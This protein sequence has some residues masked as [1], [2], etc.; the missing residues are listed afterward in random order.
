MDVQEKT[1]EQGQRN[2]SYENAI[3]CNVYD[4]QVTPRENHETGRPF[5]DVKLASGTT[6]EHDGRKLDVGRY[7]FTTN[8]EP[9]VTFGEPGDP[10]AM[11]GI[12]FPQDWDITLTKVENIAKEGHSPVFEVTDRIEGVR[13]KELADGIAERNAAWRSAHRKAH[14][15]QMPGRDEK[16]QATG[17]SAERPADSKAAKREYEP[18]L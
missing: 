2:H 4:W 3:W 11:R 5:W 1:M 7:H 14:E 12:I 18:S 10:K 17:L 13:P 9:K 16:A 8:L 6:I 15:E